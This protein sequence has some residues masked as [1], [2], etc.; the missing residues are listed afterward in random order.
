M[1]TEKP[2]LEFRAFC[3]EQIERLGVFRFQVKNIPDFNGFVFNQL[4]FG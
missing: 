4:F 2:D 3:V 1:A